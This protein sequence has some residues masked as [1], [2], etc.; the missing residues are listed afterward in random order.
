VPRFVADNQA[1]VAL[2]DG[3]ETRLYVSWNEDTETA[4]WEFFAVVGKVARTQNLG[5]ARRVSFQTALA[6]STAGLE[7]LGEDVKVFA[8]ALDSEGRALGRSGGV[9]VQEEIHPFRDGSE[10][11]EGRRPDL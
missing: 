2:R 11:V 3:G 8:E 1:V 4:A 5:V 7:V 10:R 9:K 6:V